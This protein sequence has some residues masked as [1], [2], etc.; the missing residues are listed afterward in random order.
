VHC[1]KQQHAL[2]IANVND[3]GSWRRMSRAKKSLSAAGRGEQGN[4]FGA[5]YRDIAARADWM[6]EIRSYVHTRL[7]TGSLFLAM[8]SDS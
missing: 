4:R 8:S 7:H 6:Y 5:C 3:V 1:N 2:Q